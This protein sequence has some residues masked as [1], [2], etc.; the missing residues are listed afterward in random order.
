M[1]IPEIKLDTLKI[2]AEIESEGQSQPFSEEKNTTVFKFHSKNDSESKYIAR[3]QTTKDEKKGLYIG[4]LNS[5]LEKN[6]FG[7]NCYENEDIYLGELN[8]NEREGLGIYIYDNSS[9]PE[10]QEIYIG[11]WSRNNKSGKGLMIFK[12]SNKGIELIKDNFDIVYGDFKDNF[13]SSVTT[14]SKVDDNFYYYIG[15]LDEHGK[16]SDEKAYFIEKGVKGFRGKIENNEIKSGICVEIEGKN[17]FSYSYSDGKYAVNNDQSKENE[18]KQKINAVSN[19]MLE[20][21]VSCALGELFEYVGRIFA[22]KGLDAFSQIKPDEFKG[23]IVNLINS[24]W[25]YFI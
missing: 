6:K 15:K 21:K 20:S 16:K 22:D 7:F 17:V 3:I 19:K 2:D 12:G 1:E 24:F 25:I 10:K 13:S 9:T 14:I 18:I 4:V 5:D 23:K 8:K 11:N